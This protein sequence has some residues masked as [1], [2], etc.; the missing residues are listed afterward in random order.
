MIPDSLKGVCNVFCPRCGKEIVEEAIFCP[1]CGSP[2]GVDPIENVRDSQK[3]QTIVRKKKGLLPWLIIGCIFVL[4][5]FAMIVVILYNNPQKKYERQLSLAER[6][7]NELDYEKAIATY[8]A[9]IEID[10]KNPK[11]YRGLAEMYIAIGDNESAQKVLKEGIEETGSNALVK[12]LKSIEDQD[13]QASE[14]MV[15]KEQDDS[16]SFGNG[17]VDEGD[18]INEDSKLLSEKNDHSLY[19]AFMKNEESAMITDKG[20]EALYFPIADCMYIGEYYTIDEIIRNLSYMQAGVN[21]EGPEYEYIDCGLDGKEELLVKVNFIPEVENFE[22]QMVIKELEGKLIICYDCDSWSRSDTDISYS[23][24]ISGRGSGGA[25]S[26]AFW[27]SYIDETGEWKPCYTG[28]VD[29]DYALTDFPINA[30]GVEIDLSG[31]DCGNLGLYQYTIDEKI[32]YS[33]SDYGNWGGISEQVGDA[34]TIRERFQRKGVMLYDCDE[35]NEIIEKKR[36]E[37][38]LTEEIR[39]QS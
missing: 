4:V 13:Y 17:V 3:E 29:G 6:Y 19:E 31:V 1:K 8:R 27:E 30:G 26:Y 16:E 22:F 23:G 28:W 34:A 33:L 11:A 2:T 20:H 9:A 32:Y 5:I 10:P 18:E 39:N 25:A 21:I 37:I 12:I 14:D 24:Y 7:L 35:M 15:M 38:G 36:S